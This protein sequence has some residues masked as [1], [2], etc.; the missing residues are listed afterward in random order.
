VE[1]RHKHFM[2]YVYSWW[3]GK[4]SLMIILFLPLSQ[5]T[6]SDESLVIDIEIQYLGK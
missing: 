3:F 6:I 4:K 1:G 2:N 5:L